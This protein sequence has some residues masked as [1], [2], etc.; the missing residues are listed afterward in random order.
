M[1]MVLQDSEM[2]NM[3]IRENITLLRNIPEETLVKSIKIA[4]LES[5]IAKLP[6]G[7]ETVIGEKGY[8]LSGGE[9]QRV[10][11]ARAICQDPEIIIF[12]EATSS[13]DSQT[14]SKIQKALE[15]ELEKKTLIFIAHRISTLKNADVIYVFESGKIVES[16]SYTTLL[17]K[18]NS[19]FNS[20]Y[21]TQERKGE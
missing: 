15:K 18:K 20:L 1:S 8:H 11:I 2:F 19:L 4:Q 17:N 13:L 16:G 21:I 12:D 5:V 14:E 6:N 7:L 10:G 9:R 3:T